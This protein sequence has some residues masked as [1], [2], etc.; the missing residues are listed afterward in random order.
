MVP[1]PNLPK[2]TCDGRGILQTLT[3][4]PFNSF[5]KEGG[6]QFDILQHRGF[7]PI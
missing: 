5:T 4:L 2:V 7:A 3:M 1:H 6:Q